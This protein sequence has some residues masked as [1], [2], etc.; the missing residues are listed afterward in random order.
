MEAERWLKTAQGDFETAALLLDHVRYAHACFHARKK[1]AVLLSAKLANFLP[2]PCSSVRPVQFTEV[3]S[4]A[5]LTGVFIRVPKTKKQL[6]GKAEKLT[7][8]YFGLNNQSDS[9]PPKIVS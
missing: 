4:E 3:R 5:D 2:Y 7:I 8:S 6:Q 1:C 9:P